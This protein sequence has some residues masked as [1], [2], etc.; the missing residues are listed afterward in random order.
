MTMSP[1][2]PRLKDTSPRSPERRG[3]YLYVTELQT[4]IQ[5]KQKF[6]EKVEFQCFAVDQS[7]Y[8]S[9]KTGTGNF[10]VIPCFLCGLGLFFCA[11]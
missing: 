4:E 11:G 7:I 5:D 1:R 9:S 8:K 3:I 10:S 6:L 2:S